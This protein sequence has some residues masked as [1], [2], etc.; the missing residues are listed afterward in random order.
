[1]HV[2]R[3]VRGLRKEVNAESTTDGIKYIWILRKNLGSDGFAS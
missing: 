2:L 3:E 1:M